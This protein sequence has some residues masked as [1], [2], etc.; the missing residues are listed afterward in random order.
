MMEEIK[1]DGRHNRRKRSRER[2]I[3]AAFLL[4]QRGNW[5]P[6]VKDIA[7]QA[8]VSV[9]TVFDIFGSL[10]GVYEELMRDYGTSLRYIYN[11]ALAS[12]I[13]VAA[14]AD[15]TVRLILMGRMP[16]AAEQQGER[17]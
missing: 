4:V 11:G 13:V 9:R 2:I 1:G 6:S 15:I 10:E 8:G 14:D 17:V 7:T 5:R 12:S 16:V 3:E